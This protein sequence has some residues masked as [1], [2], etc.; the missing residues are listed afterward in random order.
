[1][2]IGTLDVK[3]SELLATQLAAAG[4]PCVVL[5]AKNDEEEARIIAE[6]GALGA[7]TVSTQMAGRGVDIRLGGSDEKDRDAVVELGG[8][9]VIGS[10]RHDSRRVDDQLR[11]R[12]SPRRPGRLGVLR[13]PG[14]RP[15]HP[16][17]GRHPARVAADGHGRRGA[18]RG[19]G[20][21]RGAT[22]S[23]SPRA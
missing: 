15:D 20:V 2:L 19:G 17:R 21:R 12:A 10:G 1:M 22:Q 3:A 7:V 16:A 13:Q 14:G 4:I 9:F 5:N 18:R 11:G 23:G 6:A 8:L